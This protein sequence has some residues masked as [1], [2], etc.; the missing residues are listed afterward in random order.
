MTSLA[1][2][3][4]VKK[5]DEPSKKVVLK[6][7]DVTVIVTTPQCSKGSDDSD[8]GI[9]D[10]KDCSRESTTAESRRTHPNNKPTH[11]RINSI[12]QTNSN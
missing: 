11:S 6:K 10:V 2:G 4:K 7:E 8:D 12:A 9:R 5:A 3:A 1:G